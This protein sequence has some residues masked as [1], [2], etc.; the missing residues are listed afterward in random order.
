VTQVFLNYRRADEPFGVAMLD[1]ELSARFGSEAVFFASKSIQL[2][3][4]WEKEMFGAV[5][6]ST[7][8]LVVMGRHWLDDV[9]T[10]GRRR[11]D[12]PGD[13]VRREILLALGLQKSVIT[14]RLGV[15]RPAAEDLPAEL[16]PLLDRQ[17]IE[18]QFRTAGPDIDRL[19]SKV[20]RLIPG[21]GRPAAARTPAG[22]VTY[23]DQ[24][25][26]YDIRDLTVDTFHA[27]PS[28]HGPGRSSEPRRDEL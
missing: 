23:R 22:T 17:D 13:F 5:E 20:R 10:A 11:L 1:R 4:S 2:G 6:K 19:E 25:S 24:A 9:D 27:G 21:L 14:V 7:A 12:D 26:H 28:F 15:P 3:A 16:R 18:I 8:L